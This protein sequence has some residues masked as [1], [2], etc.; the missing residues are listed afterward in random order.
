MAAPEYFVCVN[1]ETPCYI[2]EWKSD[3][4]LEAI[5]D[6]CG[7]EDVDEFLTPE[8]FDAMIGS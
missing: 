8:D 1:C 2:F 4:L 3:E 5:C 6:V 7:N